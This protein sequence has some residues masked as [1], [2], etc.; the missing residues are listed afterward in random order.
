MLERAMLC[1]LAVPII[2]AVT[3]LANPARAGTLDEW[4]SYLAKQTE[5]ASQA[6]SSA[7][8]AVKAATPEETKQALR[9]AAAY[10]DRNTPSEAEIAAAADPYIPSKATVDR[11][12]PRKETVVAVGIGATTATVAVL[13]GKVLVP[14]MWAK[15][16]LTSAGMA[17]LT[18]GSLAWYANRQL[19]DMVR[20]QGIDVDE[21]LVQTS[22]LI[23]GAVETALLLRDSFDFS[24][25][26][27]NNSD[28]KDQYKYDVR[29]ASERSYK[30][31]IL[32]IDPGKQRGRA[33]GY[34]L[35]HIIP[36]EGC[37]RAGLSKDAC[38]SPANLQ[39]LKSSENRSIGAGPWRQLPEF[40]FLNPA[41]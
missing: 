10:V 14:L 15:Y 18:T 32:R 27:A 9:D 1:F 17:A 23:V 35:D 30:D 41:R 37:W 11:Y 22:S 29:R 34:D 25:Q 33:G 8:E 38:A 26:Y 24:G 5:A 6:A 31:S 4:G 21:E 20:E 40:G 39:M 13:G 3:I 7:Y 19:V 16:G 2:A 36:V 12:T 28:G